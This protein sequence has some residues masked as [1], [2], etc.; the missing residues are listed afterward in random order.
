M[1]FLKKNIVCVAVL[2]VALFGIGT[3]HAQENFSI[4]DYV[5]LNAI[6]SVGDNAPFWLVS[7]RNGLSSLDAH[8]GYIRYG[9]SVDG[10]IGNKGNWRY[11][12]GLDLK[13]PTDS[14]LTFTCHSPQA[15]S[16]T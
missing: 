5:Q 3:S 12:S 2:C 10:S 13:M 14:P 1:S 15:T 11:S 16:A 6:S 4:K 9:V 8:N 7:N